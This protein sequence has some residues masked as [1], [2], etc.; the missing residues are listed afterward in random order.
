M[1]GLLLMKEEGCCAVV[2]VVK[3]HVQADRIL[4]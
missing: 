1:E 2:E 3:V 4:V